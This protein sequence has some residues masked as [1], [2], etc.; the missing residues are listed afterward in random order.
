MTKRI[1]NRV[2][3]LLERTG[4]LIISDAQT[5][6]LLPVHWEALRYLQR[7]NRFSKTAGALGNY[8]GLTK[9]TVSQ[10]LNA[11]EGRGLISKRINR[12]DRRSKQ[13]SLTAKALKQLQDDPLNAMEDA[14]ASLG[15]DQQVALES[16]LQELLST[17]LLARQRQPF[18]QCYT[19][20][21]FAAH[22]AKGQPHYCQLLEEPLA[23]EEANAIC[24]EQ[25]S[26]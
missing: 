14:I 8:L 2:A 7:A 3:A 12:N 19:C 25:R 23:A 15:D 11:L 21:Y 10:T 17:R 6:G 22:H 24:Y 4:R 13:L 5:G 26:A 9:G 1:A 16:G 20:I 18:G